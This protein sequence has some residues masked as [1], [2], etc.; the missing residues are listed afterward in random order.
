M[1]NLINFF[2]KNLIESGFSKS[3]K[4]RTWYKRNEL[5]NFFVVNIQKSQWSKSYYFNVSITYHGLQNYISTWDINNPS[6]ES[7]SLHGRA[8][9]FTTDRSKE[10]L[11]LLSS[12]GIP[13]SIE[14]S[15][16]YNTFEYIINFFEENS[17]IEKFSI[18]HAKYSHLDNI[19]IGRSLRIKCENI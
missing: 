9:S 18:N 14:E 3:K 8:E 1:N 4:S 19:A 12:G 16:F 17:T 15:V 7:T 10:F 2:S 5:D 13:D 6:W 11:H